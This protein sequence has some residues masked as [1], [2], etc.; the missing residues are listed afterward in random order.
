MKGNDRE[1]GKGHRETRG[2]IQ[3]GLIRIRSQR[4]ED[5]SLPSTSPFIITMKGLV[6]ASVGKNDGG[7]EERGRGGCME[8]KE[9]RGVHREENNS[10]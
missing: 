3:K 4:K 5:K 6:D 10:V 1:D 2:C 9:R 7:R 8:K